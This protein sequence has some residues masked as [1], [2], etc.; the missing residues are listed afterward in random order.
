MAKETN[1]IGIPQTKTIGLYKSVGGLKE[2]LDELALRQDIAEVEIARQI[3]E[4]K[5]QKGWVIGGFVVLCFTV[6]AMLVGVGAIFNDY[7]AM[8]QATY[9]SLKDE[10]NDNNTKNQ[11]ILDRLNQL[12]LS[13]V[14]TSTKLTR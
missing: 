14:T 1:Y 13:T 4:S 5:E 9:Q 6:A 11:Q 7:L 8:K 12:N 2:K 10:V 3:Q